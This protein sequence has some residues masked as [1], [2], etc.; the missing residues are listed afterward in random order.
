MTL[1]VGGAWRS[2]AG[3]YDGGD[4]AQS[5]GREPQAQGGP[6]R[7]AVTAQR[8]QLAALAGV[9]WAAALGSAPA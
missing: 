8:L 7:A 2:R 4:P 3:P 9:V 6:S 5:G 1:S